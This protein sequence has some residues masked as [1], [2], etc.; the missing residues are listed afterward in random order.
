MIPRHP[1]STPQPEPLP[2]AELL[3]SDPAQR[4]QGL[5]LICTL[6][7]A[8]DARRWGAAVHALTLSKWRWMAGFAPCAQR[9]LGLGA[10]R[11]R[12]LRCFAVDCAL[13]TWRAVP[14]DS[15]DVAGL[16]ERPWKTARVVLKQV[17]RATAAQLKAAYSRAARESSW[18][19]RRLDGPNPARRAL[20]RASRAT[21]TACARH[22]GRAALEAANHAARCVRAQTIQA[23]FLTRLMRQAQP[24]WLSRVSP[25]PA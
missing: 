14:T 1:A 22:P 25:R 10:P 17:Q 13:L 20:Y 4:A 5:E 21:R 9:I 3:V 8:Q 19:S 15:A 24:A 7:S 2:L 11:S 18:V 6:G 23:W 12:V 16:W